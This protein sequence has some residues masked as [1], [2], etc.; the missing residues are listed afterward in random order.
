MS[1]DPDTEMTLDVGITATIAKPAPLDV[2]M[3]YVAQHCTQ[4]DN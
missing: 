3:G 1:S 2:I 4:L